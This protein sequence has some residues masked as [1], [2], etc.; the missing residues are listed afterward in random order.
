MVNLRIEG[1]TDSTGSAGSNQVLSQ[2]R[3]GSAATALQSRGVAANRITPSSHA[4]PP[5]MPPADGLLII[6]G[7]RIRDV[8]EELGRD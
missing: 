7:G 6:L 8:D 4:L 1:Y 5:A 3:A 2:N